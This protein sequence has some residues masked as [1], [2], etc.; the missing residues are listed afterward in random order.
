MERSATLLLKNLLRALTGNC[1]SGGISKQYFKLSF[2]CV[3]GFPRESGVVRHFKSEISGML[4][5]SGTSQYWE[6]GT[7][8]FAAGPTVGLEKLSAC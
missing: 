4:G 1:V 6:Y 5:L 3:E 7:E 8:K 2:L